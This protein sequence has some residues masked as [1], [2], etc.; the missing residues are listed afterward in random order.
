MSYTDEALKFVATQAET[1]AEKRLLHDDDRTFIVNRDGEVSEYRPNNSARV[2]LKVHMLTAIVDYVT[3]TRERLNAPL[4]IEVLD[5]DHVKVYG[6]LDRFGN[7]ECLLEAEA[8]H[9]SF[10]FGRFSDS[11]SAVIQLQSQF[12]QTENTKLLLSFVGNMK[13]DSI[14][15]SVDDGVSQTTTVRAG[16][17]TV[18][19]G[20]APNPIALRPYWTFNE[21]E[22]PES[23]FIFR[24]HEGMTVGLF[25]GD[26]G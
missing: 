4:V 3:R 6:E 19:A 18:A 23:E 15:T 9:P 13:E 25:E 7:R 12:V 24:L 2:S 26:G 22:Q 21:V 5:E 11:E 10:P 14:A 1:A 8:L 20:T 16:V 17:A